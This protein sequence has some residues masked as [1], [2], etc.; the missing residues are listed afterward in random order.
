MFGATAP[1]PLREPRRRCRG[2][3]TASCTGSSSGAQPPNPCGAEDSPS[4]Q[5][6]EAQQQIQGAC[7]QARRAQ[8]V[9]AILESLGP[10]A[11]FWA[12]PPPMGE[13]AT[14]SPRPTPAPTAPGTA[15]FGRPPEAIVLQGEALVQ[16]GASPCPHLNL[17]VLPFPGPSVSPPCCAQL[18]CGPHTPCVAPAFPSWPVQ[19]ARL[20]QAR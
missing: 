14:R 19:C 13:E 10:K 18:Q 16:G 15:V 7:F 20:P 17:F 5:A 2:L 4:L 1:A 12:S 9:N 3:C 8:G 6:R 11:I